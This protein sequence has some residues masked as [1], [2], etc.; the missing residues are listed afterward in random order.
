M[1]GGRLVEE[2]PARELAASPR[3]DY[4]RSLYAAVPKLPEP[5]VR[6]VRLYGPPTTTPRPHIDG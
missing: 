3:H 1:Q 4:T 5:F 2:A 6:Q